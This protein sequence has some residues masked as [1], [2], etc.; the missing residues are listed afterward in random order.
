MMHVNRN[1]ILVKFQHGFPEKHSCE[2]QLI[3]IAES[4]QRYLNSNK[5]VDVLILDFSKAFDKVAH[6]RLL[7]KLNHYGIRDKTCGWI[8]TLWCLIEGGVGI[9]GG[10]GVGKISKT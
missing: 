5:Q 3:M 10:G 7:P 4:I 6:Q 1:N 9:S 2:S 8:R